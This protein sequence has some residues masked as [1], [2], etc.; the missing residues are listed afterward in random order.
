M[1]PNLGDVVSQLATKAAAVTGT[2]E[3]A[4][5]TAMKF[6]QAALNVA[7]AAATLRSIELMK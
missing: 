2:D 5:N 1:E 3:K 4:S 7:Q 6:S